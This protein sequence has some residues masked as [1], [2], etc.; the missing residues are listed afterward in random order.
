MSRP[1]HFGVFA[2][3]ACCVVFLL[4]ISWWC[5]SKSAWN[6]SMTALFLAILIAVQLPHVWH[7]AK[8]RFIE[9]AFNPKEK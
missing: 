2:I 1:S 4:A 8:T 7:T 5:A 9:S 6:I 3:L